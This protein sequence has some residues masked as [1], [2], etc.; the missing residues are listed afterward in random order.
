[1]DCFP[2]NLL[3]LTRRRFLQ[4]LS[5]LKAK[6]SRI[7]L[8]KRKIIMRMNMVTVLFLATCLNMYAVGYGQQVTL[9][10]RNAS[11]EQVL[12]KIEKQT[13]YYFWFQTDLLTKSKKVTLNLKQATLAKSLVEVFKNQP[14]DYT[15][16]DKAIIIKSKGKV[17]IEEGES[18]VDKAPQRLAKTELEVRMAGA[19]LQYRPTHA[20]FNLD[21]KGTVTDEKGGGL[22]GVNV[23]VKGTTHGTITSA[24]GS[25]QLS[26][27]NSQSVLV[28]S[29]VGYESKEMAVGSVSTLNV[30]LRADVK[31]LSEVVVVG[32]SSKQ[33][34]QLSSSVSVVSAKQLNDVT[35]NNVTSLLQGKAP[36]VIVSNASGDPTA[37]SNI[38]IRGSSSITADSGPLFVVDGI[39]G[40]NANPNDVESVT[41]LKDAAATGLYGSRAANG[42]IIITTKSG[43]SGKTK[44]NFNASAGFNNPTTGNFKVMNSDQLYDY[45]KSFYPADRFDKEIPSSV[46]SLSTNWQDLA[47][48]TAATQNYVLSISGGSEKTKFY[49]AGNYYDE[50]GT[51]RHNGL[52]RYNFRA[53]ITH[54]I[55]QKLKL[56]VRLNTRLNKQ[57]ADPSGLD[58]ALYG[59]YNNM[60]FD[61]P[62]N[63]DGSINRGTEGGWYG[64]EQQNFLHSWQYNINQSN[65]T[66]VDGDVN[67]DYTIRPDLVFSTNNR[68]S[69]TNI[70]SEVYYDIRSKSGIGLGRLTNGATNSQSLITSNRLRYSKT[71]GKHD[72]TALAV[73]EAESNKLSSNAT[74]GE[75]FAPGLHVMSTASRIISGTGGISE[76]MFM[77]GLVQADYSYDNRYFAVASLINESSSRFGANNRSGNFYTLGASWILSNEEFLKGNTEFDLI[78]LR[79]SYGVTG[80]AEIGNYKALGLYSF[81]TQYAGLAGARPSQRDNRDLTWEKAKTFNVGVDLS[82]KNRILVNIDAY[83]KTTDGLLLNV[84]LPYTSGFSSIIKNVG[85]IRNRG[86]E[87]NLTSTNLKGKLHWETNFNIAF[88][89]SKV[90]VLDQGKDIRQGN[91]LISEG[92]ELYTWNMRKWAGVD[93][94]NGDPL[95]EVVSKGANGEEIKTTT[96]SYAGATLQ[97]VGSASP[98]FT[99]G[100][101]NTLSY[102]GFTLF[103]FFNFVSGNKVYNQSRGLFDSDG[104]YYTYNSMVLADGWNRWEKAGDIATHPKPVFGGNRNSNQTSSRFL[105]D[106]SYLRLRNVNFSYQLPE[107]W[108]RKIGSEQVKVYVSADNL[109]TFTKFSGMDPEVVLGPAGGTS[110]IKYPISKKVLFGINLSF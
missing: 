70:M 33:L 46:R 16:V 35:S 21:I 57:N 106:G 44:I 99:G 74:T 41:I 60:P 29:F 67:L 50:Q 48:R 54:D 79:A 64:R 100:I 42:V 69:F 83:D 84:E 75:G 4:V 3:D 93:P 76:S 80:N 94:A 95:W 85:A 55:N 20:R 87:L 26:V 24:D 28:F 108:A 97:N 1:M 11:L 17:I 6:M 104:A 73:A 40:G 14:L 19:G 47:F 68:V 88:N 9:S 61:N 49:A 38:V 98:N 66:G 78:K 96:N 102:K 103:A 8:D 27:P 52:K 31:A 2:I 23:V 5:N 45:S 25:Y 56:S 12:N 39:I 105:E 101:S 13:G 89:R 71:F 34:S 109:V 72:F 15:I 110:S 81:A 32:Y 90:L 63:A 53:N 107:N 36:G 59:A 22:P 37:S 51:L 10:E 86:L 62:Y 82:W 91:F 77:K 30:E 18:A 58:G 92:Q 65:G 7:S 43:K